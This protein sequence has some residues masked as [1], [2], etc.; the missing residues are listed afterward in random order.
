[1]PQDFTPE[2]AAEALKQE[3]TA[4]QSNV[5]LKRLIAR[6]FSGKPNREGIYAVAKFSIGKSPDRL[7]FEEVRAYQVHLASKGL[8][9]PS[10]NQ[11]ICALCVF[12]RVTLGR[13]EIPL[14]I[15]RLQRSHEHGCRG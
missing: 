2:E 13:P 14:R 10:F 15:A 6:A 1:V 3:T 5:L 11:I 12:Y 9:W 8:A 7:G 4:E